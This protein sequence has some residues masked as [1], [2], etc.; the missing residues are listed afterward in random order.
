MGKFDLTKPQVSRVSK[1]TDGLVMLWHGRNG[2]G[3]TPQAC[4]MEKPLYL[5]FGKSGLSGLNNVPF[6]PLM[7]WADFKSLNNELCNP[8][9]IAQWKEM[10]QTIIFDEME[11]ASEYCKK[12]VA[13]TNGVNKIKEGNGGYGLWGDWKEEWEAEIL[14][15]LGSSFCV[16]FIT[17]SEPT[18]DGMMFPVGDVK[19]TLPIIMNHAEI[20]GY[21]KSNGVDPE[22]G[23]VRH[24]SLEIATTP[25]W[26]G[27]T[28][29]SYFQT[30]EIE[31][32]TAENVI[33]A[34]YDALDAQSKAEGITFVSYEERQDLFKT[35]Q[36]PFNDL[37]DQ[38][39]TM[40][41]KL[42]EVAGR[43][44]LVD[45]VEKTLGKGNTVS[46]CSEKQIEALNVIYADIKAALE[47]QEVA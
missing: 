11:I 23:R 21:V 38:I 25:E 5:A 18:D 16:I 34:Y 10:Y 28:R 41:N 37:M 27:R 7:S 33:K 8:K 3:K 39:A 30:T 29:N 2:L 31:D 32:F 20:I 22:T 12:Y 44:R 40:G 26:Y 47:E 36:I 13:N 35:E 1:T 6:F 15:L 24:S 45:I 9:K 46:K 43:D 19:R 42:I 4:R 17:H 14:K